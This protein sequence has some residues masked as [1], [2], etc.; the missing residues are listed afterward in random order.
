MLPSR[1]LTASDVQPG[2]TS[3]RPRQWQDAVPESANVAPGTPTGA[4]TS[5]GAA[6]VKGRESAVEVFQLA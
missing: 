1:F 4:S 2:V 5:R 6:K 3:R